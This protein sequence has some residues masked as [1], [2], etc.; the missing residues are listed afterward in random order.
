MLK[1]GIVGLGGISKVHISG[2]QNIDGAEIVAVCD[3]REEKFEGKEFARCYKS[4]DEMLEKE[5][6]DIIDV[7]VPTYLHIEYSL[8]ALNKGINVI[9]EKPLTLNKKEVK[10]VYAAAEKNNVKFMVAQVTRFMAPYAYIKK[11][12]ESNKYGKILSGTMS[13]IGCCPTWSF[14]NWM[15]D[16]S[17][18]GMIPYDVHIHDLDFIVYTF[19]APKKATA[20]RHKSDVADYLNVIYY[21]D[22]FFINVEGAWYN[23]PKFPFGFT[24]VFEFEKATLA[25]KGGKFC[26]YDNQGG[27]TD[28]TPGKADANTGD[29]GLP[30]TNGY[31]EE[32]RYFFNCVKDNKPA[33]II[34]PKELEAVLKT[35]KTIK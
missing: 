10:K 32:L 28:I 20:R 8:K 30:S 17:K 4:Y 1:V 27:I 13:R 16:E 21:F 31:E 6:F 34:K 19:G 24:F 15:M 22:G 2:W 12:V 33:D 23:A 3:I 18:S 9:C 14:E 7:C 5:T 29:I 25:Y 11:A 26:V 35:V